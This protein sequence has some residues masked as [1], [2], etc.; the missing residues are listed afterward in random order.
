MSSFLRPAPRRFAAG[1]ALSLMCL[2]APALHAQPAPG[3]AP[4]APPLAP[5]LAA[6]PLAGAAEPGGAEIRAQLSPRR[7]TV[8]SSEIAGQIDELTLREGERFKEGQRLVALDCSLHRARLAKA[9]AQLQEARKTYEVN[10][11]LDRL[12]SVSQLEVEAAAARQAGAEAEVSLMR[13]LVERCAVAAP[14]A[15]RVADMK[16]KRHQF[17]AEGQELMEILDDRDLE[18]ETIVPSRWLSWLQPGRRFTVRL[19]ETGRDYQAEVTRLGARID[20]VSQSIKMFGRVLG[21]HEELLPGMSGRA[22][23]DPPGQGGRQ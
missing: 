6:A 1:A 21:S 14:F 8:L 22:V 20:P 2:G 19:E 10:S 9:Q 3:A 7:S 4:A 16:V 18:V 23:F 12:G 13:G 5:P 15:G 11:R 17:V